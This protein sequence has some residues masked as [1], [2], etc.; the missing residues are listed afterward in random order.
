MLYKFKSKVTSD[1]LMLE[2]NG[3]EILQIIGKFAANTP[4]QGIITPAEM[5]AAI[6]ALET[7]LAKQLSS[8]APSTPSEPPEAPDEDAT[9]E[10]ELVGLRQRA[11]PFL[12]M[13]RQSLAQE[14]PIVW[15]V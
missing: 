7:A 10:A 2:P 9:D 3:R 15:G 8:D 11:R 4:H 5:P 14:Q 12:Q 13:L 6:A 1:V